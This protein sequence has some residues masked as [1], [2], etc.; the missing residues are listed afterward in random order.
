MVNNKLIK[1]SVR[2][3]IEFVFKR[4][5][6]DDRFISKSRALEGTYA[7]KKLQKSNEEMYNNYQKEVYL[8][9]D[10][11]EI[12][13]P[14]VVEGRADGIIIEGDNIYI[15]EIKSTMKQLHYIDENFNELHWA[16]VKIYSYIYMVNNNLNNIKLLL[17]YFQLESEEVKSFEK[18]FSVKEAKE[19]VLYN[20]RAY[21]K[22]I[23]KREE[24][25]KVRNDSITKLEFPFKSYR[26]GQR[27]LAVAWYN[28]IK[29]NE[30]I[31]IQAP[32][33]IGKTIS[34]IFP[35]IKALQNDMGEK[36]FY[37]TAKTISR[38]VAEDGI[39]LLKDNGLFINSIT[40]TSKEKSCINSTFSCNPDECKYARG[41]YDKIN[42]IIYR[43]MSKGI[44]FSQEI[45]KKISIEEEVC[46]F[47]L[48]LDLSWWCDIVICD[49]NYA[50]DSRVKLA[51]YFEDKLSE[52]I[53]LVDEAHN[54]IDRGREMYSASLE[55]SVIHNIAKK[56]KGK[57]IKLYKSLTAINKF[58]ITIRHEAEE[59]EAKRFYK[60]EEYK[61]LYKLLRNFI[62][63]CDEY[64]QAARNDVEYETIKELYFDIRKFLNAV[65][66]YDENSY[67]TLIECTNSD[68]KVKLFCINP[69]KNIG[70]IINGSYAAVLFSA[71]LSP[72]KYYIDLLG[73]DD[74][75]YRLTLMTPFDPKNLDVSIIP[76]NMRYSYRNKNSNK[77]VA[78]IHKKITSKQGNY[79]VFAPSFEY[80]KNIFDIYLDTYG[81]LNLICQKEEMK[82]EERVD[83]LSN[84]HK[85]E[86]ILAFC[87]IGGLFSEGI[88]LPGEK[89]IGALIIGVGLP[90]ISYER[91][92]IKEFF[93]ELGFD[94]A[95]IY[96]GINK[97]MQAAGRVIRTESDVGSVL[98]IDDRYLTTKYKGLLPKEWY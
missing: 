9:Y 59:L 49:Y 83:F 73:G 86:P 13:I 43:W 65:E 58:M 31:Y 51:R 27:E 79:I 63:I 82:E 2:D 96:P 22:Y 72:I 25:L 29:E 93:G 91:D 15:E 21:L 4:G 5:S 20:L 77:V 50:F 39:R 11:S 90:M 14:I 40:I 89:L 36:I 94:Y 71:T 24:Y 8:K 18:N 19:F 48:A 62:I 33:G 46:P 66:L 75:S 81:D 64:L 95:Y 55:K 67:V 92:I 69:S 53:L 7:H 38:V 12:N 32:T 68:V 80:M 88:D 70:S 3:L 47:E 45:I 76:I 16:Q 61:E 87:V 10:F 84:F 35:S 28:T 52:N 17:S 44:E 6:I 98:L 23:F 30:S 41:Y 37:L 57:Q 85:D 74:T 26:K 56:I 34:T 42:D 54:L 1:V 97:V 78:E 60:K